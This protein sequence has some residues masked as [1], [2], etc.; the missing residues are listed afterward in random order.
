MALSDQGKA[1]MAYWGEIQAAAAARGNTAGAFDAINAARAVDP[2]GGFPVT[3]IG[4][5]EVYSAAA[6]IRNAGES[7]AAARDLEATTGIGQ[8]ITSDMMTTTPWSRDAQVLSTLA[9]YQ[10][11]VEAQFT[12][13]LGQAS[14]VFLTAKY[15]AAEL[16]ST[17]G[18]LVDALS[19]WAPAS[20]SLPVGTFEGIGSVSISVV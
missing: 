14:S 19:S 12:T 16:P 10:V 7:F 13:P 2:T 4:V 8:Q 17:V 3:M 5:S 18:E 15:G 1:A 9:D 11:R 6:K 20:G